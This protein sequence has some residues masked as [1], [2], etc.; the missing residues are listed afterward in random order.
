MNNEDLDT[1]YGQLS[2]N[3]QR[4]AGISPKTSETDIADTKIAYRE[5][6]FG[7]IYDRLEPNKDI[8]IA[9]LGNIHVEIDED[10]LGL[11]KVTSENLQ[12]MWEQRKD[13]WTQQCKELGIELDPF[14][15]FKYFHIQRKVFSVLGKATENKE[16]RK[17]RILEANSHMKLSETKD[18]AMCAEY[19]I[20]SAYLA[21]KLGD[22]V[23]LIMGTTLEGEE[24]W[25]EGHAFVW[26]NGENIIFDS[27]NVQSENEY[28]GLMIP[29]HNEVLQDMEEGFDIKATRIGTNL[30]AVYG[31]EAGGFGARFKE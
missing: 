31:L 14:T 29:E 16:H 21:Q 3:D 26:I 30:S 8:N 19:A 11:E 24:Q 25:R 12:N 27:V 22:S 13:S 28:P 23:H 1:K 15:V 6:Q 18:N 20:L 9:S 5:V 10:N 17:H 7:R 4:M 2:E